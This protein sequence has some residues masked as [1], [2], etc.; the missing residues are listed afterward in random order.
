MYHLAKWYREHSNNAS[1]TMCAEA[2]LPLKKPND[3]LFVDS[4]IHDVGAQEEI[5][6]AGYYVPHKK[7][8][9][10]NVTSEL[11]L[12]RTDYQMA[13]ENARTNLW[14]Y[15]EPLST[16]CPS[17]KCR[18]IPFTPPE[19][20]IAMNPSI[21]AHHGWLLCNVRCVNY[22]IDDQG[23]YL[24]RGTDGTANSTNPINTRNFLMGC[25]DPHG[26]WSG[27]W[28][29]K[30]PPLPVEYNLVIGFEDM[31]LISHGGLL[32]ASST[33]R[34]LH[35]DGLPGQVLSRLDNPG[36]SVEHVHA[37]IQRMLR[38]PRMC[39][40]NWAPMPGME[41]MYRPGHVV[42]QNGNDL[43]VQDTGLSTG[44]IS[45]SS[46]VIPLGRDLL[47]VVHEARH[48]PGAPTRFY[49]HRFALYTADGALR[50]LS[51]PFCFNDKGIEFCAGMAEQDGQ[52][53]ISYGYKDRSARVATVSIEDVVKFLCLP[54]STVY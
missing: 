29:V 6:I 3:M 24:I 4:Y 12:K 19:N 37:N 38:Q 10:Y 33:V 44:H 40:K 13:V 43:R 53:V 18:E 32:W 45:G 9:A 31:R 54:S 34:Q 25:D 8:L 14:W 21:V 5:S 46:Q 36:G 26:D 22:R 7:R 49:T 50:R 17:F 23:R 1:A 39:E 28:E 11:A 15:Y 47:G 52:L 27:P 48:I 20:W 51:L 41:W 30:A 2:I 42:D 16:F 35:A